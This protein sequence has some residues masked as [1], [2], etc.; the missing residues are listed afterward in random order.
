[1]AVMI[2]QHISLSDWDMTWD[3]HCGFDLLA[4]Y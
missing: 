3:S 1:M 2:Y 4:M